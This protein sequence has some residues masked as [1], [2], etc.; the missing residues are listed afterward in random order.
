MKAI[1]NN[2]YK[3]IIIDSSFINPH[4]TKNIFYFEYF[5]ILIFSR[6]IFLKEKKR[7]IKK[8]KLKMFSKMWVEEMWLNICH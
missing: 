8:K 5:L 2:A 7:K 4:R 1:N 6:I 3:T